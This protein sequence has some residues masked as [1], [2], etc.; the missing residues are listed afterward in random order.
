HWGGANKGLA[1]C[2]PAHGAG[3]DAILLSDDLPLRRW[4]QRARNRAA[5]AA[6]VHLSGA[7]IVWAETDEAWLDETVDGDGSALEQVFRV[8]PG[9]DV[10]PRSAAEEGPPR[11][12]PGPG[13]PSGE[14]A[15]TSLSSDDT[16]TEPDP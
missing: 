5:L 3:G 15:L 7:E 2:R 6:S 4:G 1:A 14:P 13:L 9:G 12:L 11:T 16:P 8:T 10:R